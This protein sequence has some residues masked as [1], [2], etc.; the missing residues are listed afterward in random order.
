[1]TASLTRT[2]G[3]ENY[4]RGVQSGAN[5]ENSKRGYD[6]RMES[7]GRGDAGC[8]VWTESDDRA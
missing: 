1:M 4:K 7:E 2:H 6:R 3:T 8:G 5:L